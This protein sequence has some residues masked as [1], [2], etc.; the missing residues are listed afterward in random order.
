VSSPIIRF[1]TTD[2][3]RQISALLK[4][5]SYTYFKSPTPAEA[6]AFF[7]TISEPAI[8][9]LVVRG[10]TEYVVAEASQVEV[11]AGAAGMRS[12]GMLVHLFVDPAYQGKGLGRRLWEFLRDRAMERG[13]SGTF[14]VHSSV[15]AVP[16][17]ERLG[18]QVSGAPVERH[19]GVSVP[20]TCK[21]SAE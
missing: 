2:D 13:H 7:N 18:F 3:A 20:M 16:V 11:L 1:A 12:D 19:G 21:I 15:S 10:D 17:Y 5:L 6:E 14:T 9:T 4:S 8:R